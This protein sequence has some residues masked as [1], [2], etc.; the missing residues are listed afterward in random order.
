[1][2]IVYSYLI[3]VDVELLSESSIE[4]LEREY[5]KYNVLSTDD[6]TRHFITV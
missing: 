5:R 1:M 6:L 4:G 2:C 3:A